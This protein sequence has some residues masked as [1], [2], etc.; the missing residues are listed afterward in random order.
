V[1]IRQN[2]ALALVLKPRLWLQSHLERLGVATWIVRVWG[3]VV[4]IVG[5][6]LLALLLISI[7][8]PCAQ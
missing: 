2:Q 7:F 4:G 5:L 1:V 3:A 6:L 8:N